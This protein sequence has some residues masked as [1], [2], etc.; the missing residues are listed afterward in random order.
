M[1][2]LLVRQVFLVDADT[3]SAGRVDG[4][5]FLVQRAQK[6]VQ[7]LVKNAALVGDGFISSR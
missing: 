2:R 4:R 7:F 6:L 3:W 5:R 1:F